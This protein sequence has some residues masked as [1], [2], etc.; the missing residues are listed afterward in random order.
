M[1]ELDFICSIN[2]AIDAFTEYSSQRQ[3]IGRSDQ[4]PQKIHA[5]QIF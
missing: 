2:N 4:C 3:S 5:L 1:S